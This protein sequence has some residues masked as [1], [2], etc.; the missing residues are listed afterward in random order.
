VHALGTR[1]LNF[2][3]GDSCEGE[4]VYLLAVKEHPIAEAIHK[5]VYGVCFIDT[6]VGKFHASI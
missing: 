4:S 5:K 1:T 3:A 2:F 6:C